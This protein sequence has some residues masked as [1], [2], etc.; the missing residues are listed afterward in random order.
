M[1][2]DDELLLYYY[3]DGLDAAERARIGAALSEQ[4]ELAR[5][6]HRLVARLDA[7]AAMPEVPV[8]AHTQRRWQVALDRAA[9]SAATPA[10]TAGARFLNR[11]RW[12][13]AAAAVV[14]LAVVL[15]NQ[16][17]MRVA[18]VRTTEDA[19][20]AS[21]HAAT[22]GVE[23]SSYERGLRW[24]LVSMEQRLASLDAAEPDE[25][26]RLIETIIAQNRM[27]ALAAER[28]DEPQLA[29]VLRAF[30]PILE[31][32]GGDRDELFESD[33]AQLNFELRVMQARLNAEV[34]PPIKARPVAL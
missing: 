32:L 19:S 27:Y 5:R 29:R 8:P 10:G 12:P 11:V 28:A 1:I 15:T 6:L 9:Q 14:I 17:M 13:A 25:R 31:T 21:T 16:M 4:P 23:A 20:P 24:H 33:I 3:R 7:A 18:P 22:P 34:N 26:A 30:T 2:S